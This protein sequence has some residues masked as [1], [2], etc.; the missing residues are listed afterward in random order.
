M[1]SMPEYIKWGRP[2]CKA[3]LIFGYCPRPVRDGSKYCYYCTKLRNGTATPIHREM[4]G[5]N[6]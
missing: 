4:A 2:Q 3:K 6:K 5:V 1:K